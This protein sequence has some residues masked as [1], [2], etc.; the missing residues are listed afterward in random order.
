MTKQSLNTKQAR[1]FIIESR[2]NGESDQ[3]IFNKLSEKYFD[4]QQIAGLIISIIPPEKMVKY[5]KWHYLFIALIA[6]LFIVEIG[7]LIAID[8]FES[9]GLTILLIAV[10]GLLIGYLVQLNKY[11][12][13]LYLNWYLLPILSLG[14]LSQSPL[15]CIISCIILSAL[16]GCVGVFLTRR[17][18]P[19]MRKLKKDEV[20]NYIFN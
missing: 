20:G 14:M 16:L 4:S 17:L 3:D 18:V 11:R 13:S 15:W 5:M 12:G 19:N 10:F 1:N 6:S 8:I 2:E 7:G 9:W